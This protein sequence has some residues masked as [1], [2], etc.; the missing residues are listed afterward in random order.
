M[1][2]A[3]SNQFWQSN[4]TP[5]KTTTTDKRWTLLNLHHQWELFNHDASTYLLREQQATIEFGPTMSK[6]A[7]EI[8]PEAKYNDGSPTWSMRI[9]QSLPS[10]TYLLRE[11]Q[12]TIEF[13]P[14][15]SKRSNTSTASERVRLKNTEAKTYIMNWNDCSIVQ[16]WCEYVPPKSSTTSDDRIWSDNEQASRRSNTSTASE[17]VR[18]KNTEAKTYIMNWNDCSIC[19]STYQMNKVLQPLQVLRW[20]HRLV[21]WFETLKTYW[22]A[23]W[24]ILQQYLLNLQYELNGNDQW[25]DCNELCF[26]ALKHFNLGKS[27]EGRKSSTD[28]KL[29]GWVGE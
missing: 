17:R 11:Q 7:S 19:P 18:L 4:N 16:W 20:T 10:S 6:Q 1:S 5:R 26:I 2:R 27:A 24:N 14:T 12:A 21:S 28:S 3:L 23:R 13:G 15:M 9:V 8:L 29:L 25:I 22:K